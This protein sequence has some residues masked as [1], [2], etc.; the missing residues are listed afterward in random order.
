MKKIKLLTSL[1]SIGVLAAVAP[2]TINCSTNKTSN[3]L[4]AESANTM[5]FEGKEYEL[6]DN[7]NP[8]V[9]LTVSSWGYS[10]SSDIPLK[11]GSTFRI[12]SC[13]GND[14]WNQ[15]TSLKLTSLDPNIHDISTYF[16]ASCENLETL[17]ISGFTNITSIDEEFCY[18]CRSLKHVIL[19]NKPAYEFDYV[20]PYLFF[21]VGWGRPNPDLVMDGGKYVNSYRH[22]APWSNYAKNMTGVTDYYIDYP[23]WQTPTT[24]V[25]YY[26]LASLRILDCGYQPWGAVPPITWTVDEGTDECLRAFIYTLSDTGEQYL[27]ILPTED[28]LGRINSIKISA[29]WNTYKIASGSF[30]YRSVRE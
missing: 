2:I 1:S 3:V 23:Q 15:I 12:E 30:I 14:G 11:D 19:P 27:S 26:N 18:Y 17:D 4:H 5:E 6:A 20:S 28:A 9:F 21:Q 7:I 25:N 10:Q 16:L 22:N 29:Y 13:L 24:R 8:N